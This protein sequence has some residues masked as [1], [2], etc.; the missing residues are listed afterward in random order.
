MDIGTAKE[1]N[2]PVP[3]HLIDIK[4]P[5]EKITVVEYQTLAYSIIDDLLSKNILPVL[6]GGSMLYAEAVLNGYLFNGQQKPR[7]STL[8][9]AIKIDRNLLK[10]RVAQRTQFW[11]KEGILDEIKTLLEQGVTLEWLDWCGQEYKY[12]SQHI[13]G[14]I[15][16]EEAIDKTN[17][18]INQYIKRQY[19]WWRRHPDLHWIDGIEEA[20]ALIGQFLKCDSPAG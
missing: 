4:N 3:Q 14:Q 5:G 18:S 12:F 10:A 2:L 8:K 11:L 13:L 16:L 7:Y 6:T 20:K 9:I 1:K 17:T 15:S 19:T